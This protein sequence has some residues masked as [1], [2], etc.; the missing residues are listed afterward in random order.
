MLLIRFTQCYNCGYLQK[1]LTLDSIEHKV[2]VKEY[3]KRKRLCI[4]WE[5]HIS[6]RKPLYSTWKW[7][8]N[9]ISANFHLVLFAVLKGS[10]WII[11]NEHHVFPDACLFCPWLIDYWVHC[12]FQVGRVRVTLLARST[13]YRRILNQVEVSPA[14]TSLSHFFLFLPSMLFF[15]SPAIHLLWASS[16]FLFP[17]VC[18]LY[19][20]PPSSQPLLPNIDLLSS[21]VKCL[22]KIL[23]AI[24]STS[25]K[26]LWFIW[27][28]PIFVSSLIDQTTRPSV[29]VTAGKCP[30]DC[31]FTGG[32]CGGLQIQVSYKVLATL[33]RAIQR[34][35][36]L[37]M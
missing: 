23:F 15:F 4:N 2:A 21:S 6:K 25:K 31:A 9:V 34:C 30:Q 11:L 24:N 26:G 14:P 32:Q 1:V 37:G 17:P 29:V 16:V 13:E 19:T 3:R 20:T 12:C 22:F 35:L 18:S 36:A 8:F 10:L 27:S 28:L 7:N 33:P 5:E